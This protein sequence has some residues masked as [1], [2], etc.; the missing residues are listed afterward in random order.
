M[1]GRKLQLVVFAVIFH[2]AILSGCAELSSS[3]WIA[4]DDNPKLA[5]AEYRRAME[6]TQG[7]GVDQD[8]ARGVTEFKRAAYHG[9]ASGAYMA[10]MS[11][12]TGRGVEHSYSS[13]AQWLELAAKQGHSRAQY[14]LSRLYLSG[15]GVDKDPIWA[16]FLAGKAAA[17]DHPKAAFE[18]G[19]GYAKGLGLPASNASAWY[20]FS[21]AEKLQ[22]EH[23][24]QL[25]RKMQ[26]LT[27]SVQ[28]QRISQYMKLRQ[29]PDRVTAQYI[30]QQLKRMGYLKGSVDGIWGLQSRVAFSRYTQ[31]ELLLSDVAIDW[32]TLQLLRDTH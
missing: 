8:Y 4:T 9:S 5:Q 3:G 6:Y 12:L 17:Q 31:K 21:Q 28:R 30:Q 22:I 18:V 13:A 24:V 7:R 27:T 11:Y 1:Q 15:K 2:M 32:S 19:V 20:W 23:S 29:Q 16:M 10:G 26:G 14:Q 25:R